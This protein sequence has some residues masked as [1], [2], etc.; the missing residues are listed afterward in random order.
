MK[1]EIIEIRPTYAVV[2]ADSDQRVSL[3]DIYDSARDR[4][5]V[6]TTPY[7]QVAGL[8]SALFEEYVDEITHALDNLS[9]GITNS[10]TV[11][12][13]LELT[14][15]FL[16]LRVQ[17]L[18]LQLTYLGGVVVDVAHVDKTMEKYH[19]VALSWIWLKLI[20]Q[21]FDDKNVAGIEERLPSTARV[22]AA[23]A[24]VVR[25]VSKGVL[26]TGHVPLKF[27]EQVEATGCPIEPGSLDFIDGDSAY[28][29]RAIGPRP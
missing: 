12:H 27:A 7:R 14:L 20:G 23:Y 29:E 15:D 6:Y 24:A 26:M 16:E 3:W 9:P 25:A 5:R 18:D 2:L 4:P 11:E 17:G 19:R 22:Y 10:S 28:F 1:V 8:I 21:V 13:L